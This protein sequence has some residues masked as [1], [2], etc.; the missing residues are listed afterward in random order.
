MEEGRTHSGQCCY[1]CCD[2]CF[3][4]DTEY[5]TVKT[6]RRIEWTR[7]N[8]N[9]QLSPRSCLSRKN[10]CNVNAAWCLLCCNLFCGY[11]NDCIMGARTTVEYLSCGCGGLVCSKKVELKKRS[12]FWGLLSI[13]WMFVGLGHLRCREM[14]GTV[15]C[16]EA[17]VE[18]GILAPPP[19]TPEELEA[20]QQ[21]HDDRMGDYY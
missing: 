14:V 19:P 8:P 2:L 13:P 5:I 6:K 10:S 20:R 4:N 12:L 1:V 11:E 18:C 16:H 3:M 17:V 7:A 9:G 21:D 15:C